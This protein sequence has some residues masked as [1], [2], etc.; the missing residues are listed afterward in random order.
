MSLNK[1]QLI[2]NVGNYPD[3]KKF[4]NGGMIAQFRMATTD[5]AYKLQNGTEVP[6]RTEWHN[7]VLQN[8]LA[9]VAEAYISK[10][11]KLYIE[12]KLRTRSYESNGVTKYIVEVYASNMEMLSHSNG[13][14]QPPTHACQGDQYQT[15][16]FQGGEL[17]F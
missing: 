12:G 8:G 13:G 10:G 9:K 3:V 4:D 2:G 15:N 11:D 6:A 14:D 7:I 1:V 5:K 17:P 16:E